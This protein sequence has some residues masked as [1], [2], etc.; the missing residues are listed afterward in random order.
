L[1]IFL[2]ILT[3]FASLISPSTQASPVAKKR[4]VLYA[5]LLD[6]LPV[7]LADGAQWMMDKGDTFPVLM[8]KDQHSRVIL[9]LVGTNFS[10]D[11]KNIRIF[12]EKDLTAESLANYRQNVQTY[13]N[14]RSDQ[15]KKHADVSPTPRPPIPPNPQP[16]TPT[17][18]SPSKLPLPINSQPLN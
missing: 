18:N 16:K 17:K 12:E 6:T 4:Y 15:W 8:F 2:C 3:F 14:T 10:V 11:T 13:I 1:K 9:Q 7:D 5:T